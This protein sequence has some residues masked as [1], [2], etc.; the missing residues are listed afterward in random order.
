[1]PDDSSRKESKKEK[2]LLLNNTIN[3][4]TTI[5]QLSAKK[6][7]NDTEWLFVEKLSRMNIPIFRTRTFDALVKVK[8]E[9]YAVEIKKASVKRGNSYIVTFHYPTYDVQRVVAKIFG[10]KRL[11]VLYNSSNEWLV[12]D[13]KDFDEKMRKSPTNPHKLALRSIHTRYLKLLEKWLEGK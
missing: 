9:I 10:F 5:K 7:G 11:I 8:G 4:F 13:P 6:K 2:E 12:L 1:M 3:E